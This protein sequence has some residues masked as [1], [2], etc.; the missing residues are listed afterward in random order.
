LEAVIEIGFD[1]A[2]DIFEAFGKLDPAQSSSSQIQLSTSKSLNSVAF[3]QHRR[4]TTRRDL[5]AQSA[6][7]VGL[8]SLRP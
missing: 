1:P 6:P 2:A 8:K 4:Q 5:A 7:E 3:K